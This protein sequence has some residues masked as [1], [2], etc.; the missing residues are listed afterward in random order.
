MTPA[1][2]TLAATDL[3]HLSINTIRTLSIDKVHQAKSGHPATPMALA[4]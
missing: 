3:D 4:R 1:A 2:Q